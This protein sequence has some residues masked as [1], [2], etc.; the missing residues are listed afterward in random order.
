MSWKLNL[1]ISTLIWADWALIVSAILLFILG[2]AHT[3]FGKKAYGLGSNMHIFKKNG[4]WTPEGAKQV[5]LVGVFYMISFSWWESSLVLLL[6]ILV[7]NP[8]GLWLGLI[9]LLS[10]ILQLV[11]LYKFVRWNFIAQGIFLLHAITIILWMIFV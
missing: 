4:E 1:Q 6:L 5:T 11:L 3:L 10:T 9:S 7:G 8:L 2:I